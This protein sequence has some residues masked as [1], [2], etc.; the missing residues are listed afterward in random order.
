MVIN[1]FEQQYIKRENIR[2]GIVEKAT[3]KLIGTIVL[4]N[5]RHHIFADLGYDLA[6]SAWGKGYMQEALTAVLS[7]ADTDLGLKRI[8][9][10]VRPENA[11]SLKLLAK[12]GFIQEGLLHQAGFH[13]TT[14][15][16]YDIMV[17][18]KVLS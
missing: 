14:K 1:L 5:F 18:G 7:Y 17:L 12:L 11:A 8:S 16:T 13:E 10:Y 9:A 6:F 4:G 15:E 3:Q 2:W